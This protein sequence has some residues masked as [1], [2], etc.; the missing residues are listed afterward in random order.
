M[1]LEEIRMR[2]DTP[3]D[4]VHDLFAEALFPGHPLGREVAGT[5]D[6]DHCDGAWRRSPRS[7]RE[8]YRPVAVVVAAAGNLDHDVI[9]ERVGA[10]LRRRGAARRRR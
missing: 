3:D 2:D 8:H 7:T 4:L 1:I 10:E 9:V 6:D 5:D